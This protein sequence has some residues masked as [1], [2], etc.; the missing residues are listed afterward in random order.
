MLKRKYFNPEELP[1]KNWVK[2]Y[3]ETLK[4]LERK[5]KWENTEQPK[6]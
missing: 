3:S 1:Q 6:L 5:E 2:F 4:T